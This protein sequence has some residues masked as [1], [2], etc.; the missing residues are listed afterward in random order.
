[1]RLVCPSHCRYATQICHQCGHVLIAH[2]TER[3]VRHY[4]AEHRTIRTHPEPYRVDNLA[5]GPFADAVGRVW[6]DIGA[7]KRT[8]GGF[9]RPSA[10]IDWPILGSVTAPATGQGKN[11]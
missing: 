5:V 4:W 3:R 7:I 2:T 11:I 9:E 6:R 8:I 10:G 1:M